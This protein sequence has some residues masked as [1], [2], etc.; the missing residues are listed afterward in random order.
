LIGD[1]IF[2]LVSRV[3]SALQPLGFAPE[4]RTFTPHLT[5]GRW[6]EI[7]RAPKSLGPQL[8]NWQTHDFGASKVESVKLIQSLL[9]P[10]GAS[11][12]ILMTVPLEECD[13]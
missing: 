5:I 8:A 4:A 10:R 7:D 3:E 11:Y 12:K 1:R 13:R 2:S 9:S 6:R